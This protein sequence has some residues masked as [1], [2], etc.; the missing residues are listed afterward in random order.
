MNSRQY[1]KMMQEALHATLTQS[2]I[3]PDD[4]ARVSLSADRTEYELT[5]KDG[6]IRVV[7]SGFEY[8]QD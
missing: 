4:Y 2:G 7:A 3:G 8:F 6:S 5:M 1:E